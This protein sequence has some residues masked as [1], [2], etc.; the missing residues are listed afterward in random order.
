MTKIS[1]VST[2]FRSSGTIEQFLKRSIGALKEVSDDF[3]V[4]LVEDG[5]PEKSGDVAKSTPE[6]IGHLQLVRLSRN[7]G[8]HVAIMAG[9]EQSKG[10]LIFLIDSDLEEKPEWLV[11]FHELLAS[12]H[13]DVVYG[14]QQKRKGGFVEKVT[15][16]LYWKAIIFLSDG[17]LRPNICTARLMTRRYL[18]S[19]LEFRDR[20]LILGVVL[21]LAGFRQ[22]GVSVVKGYRGKSN[23]GA[24]EKASILARSLVSFGRKPL[25]FLILSSFLLAS[26]MVLVSVTLVT[27]S[28]VQ[29]ASVPGWASVL[30][31]SA[32]FGLLNAGM[33]G[34]IG[35]YVASIQLE[36]KT[37]PR[38]V[39]ESVEDI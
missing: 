39:I 15:G 37:R 31:A 18:D 9:L 22:K 23:Y 24:L 6:A 1:L 5:C 14:Y 20:D 12:E 2:L 29:G 28:I 10:D 21:S 32:F 30:T 27:A 26:I 38:F 19:L 4:I 13:V 17:L 16:A 7:Y 8:H 3:E 11:H 35:L 25:F 34:L 36:T 33:L